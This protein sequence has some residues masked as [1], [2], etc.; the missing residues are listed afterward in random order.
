MES[1]ETAERT[2]AA[3]DLGSN[4]FHMVVAREREGQLQVLDRLREMVRLAAGLDEHNDITPAAMERALACLERF[5][6]RLRE[7]PH[8]NVRVVGTNTLRKARNSRRFMR[9]ASSRI[10]HPIEIISGIEEARLIYLGVSHS[11]EDDGG[12]RLVMDIG[13]GSTEF[14]LGQRFQP[15][16]MESL[17]MGC[18]SMSQRFFGDGRITEKR[19]RN[20]VLAARQELE[21]IE[22]RFRELGWDHAI[23]ASGSLLAIRDVVVSSGWSQ[24][25]ITTD[26]LQELREALLRAG[27]AQA[28]DLP[29]L[30]PERRDIFAGAVAIVLATF[31]GLGI[32]MMKVS[33]GAL[34][35]GLL[36]DLLGRIHHEDVREN[37]VQ[38]LMRRFG[39]DAAQAARVE[40]TALSLLDQAARAWGLE[41]EAERNLIS[42][43]ARLHEIGLAISHSRFHRHGAYL[44]ENMDL[45]GFSRNE[46]ARLAALV[47]A[48]R[49]KFPKAPF[50]RFPRD[51]GRDLRR[52]AV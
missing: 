18:V 28:L 30:Q 33:Q 48:H 39:I 8:E 23:G 38:A 46:Q 10:G 11:L 13:G 4:S 19:L 15:Q 3:V 47:R 31:E 7:L 26:S 21:G 2:L 27:H 5:G 12:R 17:Y 1:D 24:D 37:T 45:P 36:Y 49:R 20:A 25:G 22:A 52:S 40:K 50:R 9:L 29:G 42:M 35:E 51:E 34:R 41:G 6:Q 16:E 43:A 14:I 44:L 32:S